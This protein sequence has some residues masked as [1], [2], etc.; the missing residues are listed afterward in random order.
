M[1]KPLVKVFT[2]AVVLTVG[3]VAFADTLDDLATLKQINGYRDWTRIN[4][5][6]IVLIGTDSLVT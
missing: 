5:Q 3:G 2:L 6:P 1:K 4:Q